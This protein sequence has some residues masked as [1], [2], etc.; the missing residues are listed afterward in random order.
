MRVTIK[1]K[2]VMHFD[3]EVEMTKEEFEKLMNCDD[4]DIMQRNHPQEYSILEGY[5]NFSNVFDS[6]S[7]FTDVEVSR[8]KDAS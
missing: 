4:N 8:V 7:E 3:Q 6:D 1:C 5:I 2:Q